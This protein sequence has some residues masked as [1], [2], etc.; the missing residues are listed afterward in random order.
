MDLEF[1]PHG[2]Y[3]YAVHPCMSKD[4]TLGEG[5]LNLDAHEKVDGVKRFIEEFGPSMTDTV[6][7][8]A[9]TFVA[10]VADKDAKYMSGRYID[11]TQDLGMV[12]EEA[13]KG[14]ESRIEREG[15][16]LLKVDTL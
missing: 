5:A 4:T 7:L 11:S 6:R 9:D 10:L 13:R 8:P 14:P 3:S 12:L 15:L 16:Y 1:R 2:I